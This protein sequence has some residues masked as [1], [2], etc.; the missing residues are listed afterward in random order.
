VSLSGLVLPTPTLF[1]DDGQLDPD[2]NRRFIE[3][4]VHD[5]VTRVFPLG[6]LGEFPIVD[7]GERSVL[8]RSVRDGAADGAELWVGVGA[9][10]TRQAVRHV[11]EAERLGA[12]GLIAVPPFYL[13]PTEASVADHFR[14]LKRATSLP[15]FAYNI[16]GKVGYAL[17]PALVRRLAEEGVLQGLKDTAGSIAS[18]RAFLAALPTG[19]PVLPGDDG[20][21][22]DAVRAGAAGAVM[23]TANVAPRLGLRLLE[24]LRQEKTEEAKRLQALVDRLAAVLEL[25]P[26]PSTGK[27][28]AHH[29]RGAP[30][31][32]REPYG[33]LTDDER[34]A[35]LAGF[36]PLEASFEEFLREP[37]P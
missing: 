2:R 6:S 19:F 30:D 8:L 16:P 12:Q 14:A 35:V 22:S 27:F 36:A 29:V 26:F 5:G 31:G 9:A 17:A 11:Q 33:P 18:V 28:L 34:R 32:Y 24:A 21:A 7:E 13:R 10:A 1:D 15:L 3:G 4:L 25:G 20:L 23:G 37:L